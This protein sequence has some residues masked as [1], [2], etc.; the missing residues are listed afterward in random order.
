M[1]K[2]IKASYSH[3][4]MCIGD[5]NEVLHRSEHEGGQERSLAQIEGFREAVDVCGLSDLGYEGRRW[6]YEKKVAGGSYC[7]VRLDRALASAEWRS[8]FPLA[9]VE[10]LV[11]TSSDHGPI[12]LRWEP[13]EDVRAAKRSTGNFRYGLMWE[14]HTEFS[15]MMV[16][17][18]QD[19]G[20]AHSLHELQQKLTRVAGELQGW[21]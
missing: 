21:G 9:T 20:E 4:W 19:G 5:F 18:W 16:Q 15:P 11:A 8:R 6:T 2:F 7:G 3:P 10:N 17:T 12:L 13:K 14:S 1:L